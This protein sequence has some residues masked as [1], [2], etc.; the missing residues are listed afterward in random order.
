MKI[1]IFWTLI[2]TMTKNKEFFKILV[3]KKYGIKHLDRHIRLLQG[4]QRSLM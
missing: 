1:E 4:Y 3:V 2:F